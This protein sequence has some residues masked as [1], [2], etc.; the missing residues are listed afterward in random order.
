MLALTCLLMVSCGNMGQVMSAMTNGTGIA[1]AVKSVIGLDKLKTQ[2]LIGD[3]KYK[4]P[5]CAFT[6]ENLLAKA[7]GEIAAVQIETPPS[8]SKKTVPSLLKLSAPHSTANILSTKRL[9]RLH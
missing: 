3:W 7:G 4:G 6:S 2:Q 1:N 5:G 8:A 9:R